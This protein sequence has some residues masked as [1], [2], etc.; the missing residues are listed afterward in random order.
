MISVKAGV[1]KTLPNINLYL[2]TWTL[3]E[4]SMLTFETLLKLLVSFLL[5]EC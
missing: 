4:F 1:P 2:K 5:Y 3:L